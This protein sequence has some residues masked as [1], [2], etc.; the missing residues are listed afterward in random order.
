MIEMFAAIIRGVFS[1]FTMKTGAIARRSA[2]RARNAL[3]SVCA[4][5]DASSDR[6]CLPSHGRKHINDSIA[7]TSANGDAR[8]VRSIKVLVQ[9]SFLFAHSQSQQTNSDPM[10]PTA[11]EVGA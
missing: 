6:I 1:V 10:L 2:G 7:Q 9:S 4:D 3:P 8:L 5:M 11:N